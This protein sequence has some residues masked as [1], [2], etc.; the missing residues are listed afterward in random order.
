MREITKKRLEF[1]LNMFV[2][3]KNAK[4]TIIENVLCD[5]VYGAVSSNFDRYFGD[6][7]TI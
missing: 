7:L 3:Y 4:N 5:E 2:T 6:V 1:I